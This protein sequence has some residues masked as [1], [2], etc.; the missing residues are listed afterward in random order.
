MHKQIP[1]PLI[2]ERVNG[3]GSGLFALCEHGNIRAAFAHRRIREKPPS[4]GVSVLREA[5]PVEPA[6]LRYAEKLLSAL[7]WHGVAMVEFKFD[8]AD[9]TP[10]LMEING[11]FWG[12]LQ[13][14]V[15]AGVDF[16]WLL[17]CMYQGKP[18]ENNL[19]YRS[20]VKTRWFLGDVDHLLIVWTHRRKSLAL[21]PNHPGRLKTALLFL[22][23]FRPSV[24]SE[25]LKMSDMVPAW[26]EFRQYLRESWRSVK[27]RLG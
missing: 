7:N 16:P 9:M 5:I 26:V 3:P 23:S 24:K 22:T 1:L 27:G 11:R 20:G 17:Y 18:M 8:N 13:L 25:V 14:A 6:T 15:D 19:A 2:Q 4:G 10:K 21:P 12:S